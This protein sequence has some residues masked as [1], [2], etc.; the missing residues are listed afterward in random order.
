MD[1]GVVADP[2]ISLHASPAHLSDV[3]CI[4]DTGPRKNFDIIFTLQPLKS[5]DNVKILSR[6]VQPSGYNTRT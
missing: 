3:I 6:P 2:K 5:K 1:M 4:E